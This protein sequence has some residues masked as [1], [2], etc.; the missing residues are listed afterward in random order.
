MPRGSAARIAG[1]AA[2]PHLFARLL[3]HLRYTKL[4]LLLFG[5]GLVFGFVVVVGEF[6]EWEK[7]ASAMMALG[8]VLLPVA[9]F[10]DGRGTVVLSWIAAR[11]SRGKRRKPA[12]GKTRASA[13]RRPHR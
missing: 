13:P 11:F 3:G 4:A 1:G 6:A 9:L 10:A 12:R 2:A 7:A 8:L 5:L